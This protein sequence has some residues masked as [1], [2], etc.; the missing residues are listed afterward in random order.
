MELK[1]NTNQEKY[2]KENTRRF[3]IDTKNTIIEWYGKKTTGAHN[4]NIQMEK[5]ALILNKDG[6][7]VS[8][9]FMI[10][11]NSINCTD[12]N[13]N[14]K[15]SIEEHLKDDDFFGT[16]K[17]P[18]ASFIIKAADADRIYGT[19][20]IKGISKQIDFPYS[21]INKHQ[22]KAEIKIDRTLFDIKYKSKTIFP[23]LGDNFIHDDF[24]IKLNPLSITK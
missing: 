13:G 11:M 1:E 8:G 16:D 9:K 5:G 14:K 3:N 24:I 18:T 17:H 12:L 10:D 22:Y 23:E 7:I 2:S 21:K 19:L 15:Q 6:E 4:G 20:T